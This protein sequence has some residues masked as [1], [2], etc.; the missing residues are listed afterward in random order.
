MVQTCKCNLHCVNMKLFIAKDVLEPAYYE[1]KDFWYI[2][3]NGRE[4]LYND[5]NE[6]ITFET[7]ELA[8]EYLEKLA[9]HYHYSTLTP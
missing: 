5:N 2:S 3:R 6:W 8:E 4:T 1:R 9:N 7:K